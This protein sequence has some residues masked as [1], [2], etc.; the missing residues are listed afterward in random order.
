VRAQRAGVDASIRLARFA[1]TTRSF[2]PAFPAASKAVSSSVKRPGRLGRHEN[3]YGPAKR[4]SKTVPF[5]RGVTLPDTD[6]VGCSSGD[7][8]VERRDRD[9]RRVRSGQ[10]AAEPA[11]ST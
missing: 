5:T 1:E 10:V 7:E 8:A 4:V 9:G 6:A 2:R 3:A 11:R